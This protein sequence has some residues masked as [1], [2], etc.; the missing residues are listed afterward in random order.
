MSVMVV[1]T[2]LVVSFVVRHLVLVSIQGRVRRAQRTFPYAEDAT[3][4]GGA[5][6]EAA[7]GPAARAQRALQND[8]ENVPA[9]LL[10]SG[11]YAAL[12]GDARWLAALGVSFWLA[13]VVHAAAMIRPRQPLRNRAYVVGL[14]LLLVM[15][16]L[17]VARALG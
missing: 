10:V 15:S 4:W 7:D 6:G 2:L 3:F 14:V 11:G 8:H 13:R 12:G 9:F 1:W 17:A 5:V 16:G